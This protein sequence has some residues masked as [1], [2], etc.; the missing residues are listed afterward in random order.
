MT[1]ILNLEGQTSIREKIV[2]VLKYENY[3]VFNAPKGLNGVM[4]ARDNKLD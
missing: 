3:E 4:S 1:K 2:I